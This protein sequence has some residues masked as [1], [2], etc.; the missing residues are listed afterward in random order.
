MTGNDTRPNAHRGWDEL[1]TSPAN[2]TVK[3]ARSLHR[4]RVRQRERAMLVEGVR[5]IL[6]AHDLDVRIRALLID[7]SRAADVAA[8]V[9]RLRDASGRVLLIDPVLFKDITDTEHPQPLVAIC[10]MVDLELPNDSSF[11]VALDAVRDSGNFGTLIRSCAAA[12]AD[13]VALLPGTV[14]PYNPKAL[15][16]SVGSIFATPVQPFAGLDD[17]IQR[18]FLTCPV[19]VVADADGDRTYDNVDWTAP[20]LLIIGGE[21]DGISEAVRTYADFTVTIPMVPGI[22]SLN[23]AVAGSIIAFEVARQRRLSR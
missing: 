22:E 21:A 16:A 10:E 13:G 2:P 7:A 14:D 12:G 23:A 18:C 1:I 4:K 19:V 11:V 9:A 17:I 8:V 20:S 6:T 15:R 3:L 5:S